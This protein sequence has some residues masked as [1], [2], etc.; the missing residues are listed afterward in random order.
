M[1]PE[2]SF[3]IKVK[4][5]LQSFGNQI[6]HF[7]V[8]GG[9]YQR[10]GIPDLIACV[11]GIFVAI[12]LKSD[13]GKASELQKYNIK[14]INKSNGLGIILYP[15]G[16]ESFKKIIEEVVNCNAHT[17]ALNALKSAPINTSCNILND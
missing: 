13:S 15:T 4:K 1:S 7:K 3:E 12:E 14:L 2:K 6:W 11:N 5:Y 9:G 10:S 17:L 8:W 16:F